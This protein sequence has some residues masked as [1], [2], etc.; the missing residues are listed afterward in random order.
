MKRKKTPCPV[1]YANATDE[2][3]KGPDAAVQPT[4]EDIELM[5]E[6]ADLIDGG[7]IGECDIV[8]IQSHYLLFI[9][10]QIQKCWFDSTRAGAMNE[11]TL[12]TCSC[13]LFT[14]DSSI[15]MREQRCCRAIYP[16]F[17]LV[18]SSSH[19]SWCDESHEVSQ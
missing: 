11:T 10:S 17:S 4:A 9:C 16:Q 2:S 13:V 3:A 18:S 8:R 15:I 7:E 14:F 19:S 1:K 12:F 6:T 5:K